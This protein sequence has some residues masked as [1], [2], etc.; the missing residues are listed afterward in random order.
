LTTNICSRIENDIQLDESSVWV[1]QKSKPSY[2]ADGSVEYLR[3][4]MHKAKDLSSNSYELE[5]W[6]KDWPSEYHLSRKRSQLLR[7]FNFDRSS[8]VLEVGCGCGAI[9]SFLGEKFDD[10]I[11]IEESLVCA[12]VAR[13]RT[14]G[15]NHVE[16][17]C[18]PFQEIKFKEKF[19][20]VFGIG[21]FEHSTVFVD[22]D[23]YDRILKYF[24]DILAPDGVVVI[25]IENQ[26]GLKY[27]SSSQE[28]H[29]SL[30]FEGLEGY[31]HY[32]TQR[33]RTF[34]YIELKNRLNQHFQCIDYYFPYPNYK[35]PSCILS[36]RFFSI[37]G[38]GE[39]VGRFS[40]SRYLAPKKSSFNERL[41]LLELAKNKMLPFFSNSFLIVAGKRAIPTVKFEQ[42]GVIYTDRRVEKF[43]TITSLTMDDKSNIYVQKKRITERNN[44]KSSVVNLRS[45]DS[46]WIE[47][48]SIHTQIIKRMKEKNLEIEELF[49][50]SKIWVSTITSLSTQKNNEL[51]VDGKY[52]DCI[53]SNSFA[54]NGVCEFVDLEWEWHERI[55]LNILIIRCLFYLLDD[56]ATMKDLNKAVKA[57][58]KM[59]LIKNISKSLGVVLSNEDFKQFCKIEAKFSQC[60][61]G[62]QFNRIW[63]SIN[64]ALKNK[65]LYIIV[66]SIVSLLK[67]I[68]SRYFVKSL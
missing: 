27:F 49:A 1:L 65:I 25:A 39:L 10:V 56:V 37:A 61:Y 41:V 22:D 6:I 29:T 8:K 16:I 48:F 35:T 59:R 43:Q 68:T 66:S 30:M 58:S 47:A 19:D 51:F 12:N 32:G 45:C 60:V 9:T 62:G 40:P 36:H 57:N 31:P 2:Y 34:G 26:F 17:V 67:R 5:R 53:W 23:P 46:K 15:M 55:K 7:G 3:K 21:V 63:F 33:P 4:I 64:L 54:I 28:D 44:I 11:S 38:G 18:A 13:L 50:P 42:L 20:I 52:I 24:H 14:K